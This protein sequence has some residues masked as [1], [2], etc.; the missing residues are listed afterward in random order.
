MGLIDEIGNIDDAIE[1]AAAMI[2]LKG[3]PLVISERKPTGIEKW[4][5]TKIENLGLKSQNQA[6]LQYKIR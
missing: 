4:L 6:I 2:G 5:D 1:G 3:R